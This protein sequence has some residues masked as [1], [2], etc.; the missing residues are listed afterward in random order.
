MTANRL[1][2]LSFAAILFAGIGLSGFDRVH[3]LLYVPLAFSTFAGL[4]GV[5]VNL[6]FWKSLGF[7]EKP[8]ACLRRR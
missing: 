7:E 6:I 5:C 4:T 3:W 1:L 2:Y 8:A